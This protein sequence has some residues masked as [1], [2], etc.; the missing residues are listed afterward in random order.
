MKSMH[1]LGGSI[2]GRPWTKIGYGLGLMMGEMGNAGQVYGHS[3]VGHE[4]VSA[5]YSF[6]ELQGTR[7]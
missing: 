4:N 5:L 1:A 3:G 6:L 2:A 7:S